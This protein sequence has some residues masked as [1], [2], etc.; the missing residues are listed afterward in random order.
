MEFLPRLMSECTKTKSA[1]TPT[2]AVTAEGRMSQETNLN[3]ILQAVKDITEGQWTHDVDVDAKGMI[4]ELAF[5]INQTLKNLRRLDENLGVGVQETP[6]ALSEVQVIIDQTEKATLRVLDQ[7]ESILEQ[8]QGLRDD[9]EILQ[10]KQNIDK[11][12]L[13]SMEGRLA[14]ME[15]NAYELINSM[16]FQDITQQKIISITHCLENLEKRLVDLLIIFKI[17]NAKEDSQEEVALL[18]TL[19]NPEEAQTNNQGLVDQLLAEFG[20]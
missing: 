2:E 11:H 14:R 19:H 7:S 4:G 13:Q 8:S 16:E 10:K 20:I 9:L 6:R 17:K 5:Y 3:S 1:I 18:K 12:L 15:Q